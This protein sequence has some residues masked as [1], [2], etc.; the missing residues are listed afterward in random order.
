MIA[1]LRKIRVI[2]SVI[3][4]ILTALIFIDF[5]NYLPLWLNKYILY[6]QF[7]PSLF[8]FINILSISAAGF[9]VILLLTLFSGRVYCSSICP[10]GT[11][12]DIIN[13][14][15][16]K[17]NKKKRFRMF[18]PYSILR[19]SLL[20]LTILSAALG[21]MFIL[22]LLDPYSN[23]GRMFS[24]LV[25]P[26]A[27][28]INNSIA[29][30]LE[31]FKNYSLYPYEFKGISP[32]LVILPAAFF[33][34]IAFMSF[35]KGRLYCNS[36]CPVGTLLGLVSRCSIIKLS[37]D[38]DNCKSCG[39]CERVCKA[40]C[41][42]NKNKNIDFSRC[43]SCFNCIESC[44][45]S[46]INFRVLQFKGKDQ[47]QCLDVKEKVKPA[48]INL[49]KRDFL[50]ATSVFL[51]GVKKITY[52]QKK[53]IKSYKDSTVPVFRKNP[54]TP[55]GSLGKDHFTGSCT[56]CHLCV[57]ACPTQVL[58][59]A[60]LEYGLLGIMQP[61]M[62]YKKSFC[63]FECNICSDICPNGAILPLNAEKKK[64]LQLGRAKFVKDNC[65]VYTENTDCGACSEHC[66]TKAVSMIQ[67][68]KLT[69]P[70]VNEEICIGCGAC[71]Y[72]CP[73]KPYKAI[74]VEGNP[75]HLTAKKPKVNKSEQKIDYKEDFP[76]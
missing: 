25:R 72:A 66:P 71:E 51:I 48:E 76:F 55:P 50:I 45:G 42:D 9:V 10:L 4:F 18:K 14:I 61:K 41:I 68:K 74:Y 23:F 2:V 30:T 11:M 3:F 52:A 31:Q 43:V 62:D 39:R 7:V 1:N 46:G 21:S 54:V 35:T 65:I 15:S 59:P 38:K 34:F 73:A 13:W 64:T 53:V 58:Q 40:G 44:P 70:K 12:Q 33:L 5:K 6:L 47:E 22:N 29:F 16:K 26:S 75:V 20:G 49:S 17:I 69:A 24:N 27:V 37:I 67:D 56:A 28:W 57:S 36:I 8:K 60:Y 63:N 32:L 19:Y